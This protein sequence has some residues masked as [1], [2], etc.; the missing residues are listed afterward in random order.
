[1]KV[2]IVDED[3]D[4]FLLQVFSDGSEKRL[5][6]VEEPTRKKRLSA[7]IAWYWDLKTGRRK[8]Y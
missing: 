6:I 3:D 4:R 1:M 8:F 7:K 5:P 2:E